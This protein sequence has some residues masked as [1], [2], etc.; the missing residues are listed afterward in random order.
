MRRALVCLCATLIGSLL[1]LVTSLAS[2]AGAV[3]SVT[4][5]YPW[6]GSPVPT[7]GSTVSGI[8]N[9]NLV[10]PGTDWT[11]GYSVQLSCQLEVPSG[12]AAQF[13]G[14]SPAIP[15]NGGQSY[16]PGGPGWEAGSGAY[17]G[18]IW[19]IQICGLDTNYQPVDGAS[20]DPMSDC[21]P[22]QTLFMSASTEPVVYQGSLGDYTACYANGIPG[23]PPQS[24]TLLGCSG[25]DYQCWNLYSQVHSLN[26][27]PAETASDGHSYESVAL[28]EDTVW[29]TDPSCDTCG[30]GS[31]TGP[32]N[33][34]MLGRPATAIAS[35]DDQQSTCSSS[36]YSSTDDEKWN[37]TDLSIN[38]ALAQA[39]YSYGSSLPGY[40]STNLEIGT[41]T[42][43]TLPTSWG[44][45]MPAEYL[46]GGSATIADAP[47][48][49]VAVNGP[50]YQPLPGGD[51]GVDAGTDSTYTFVV[52]GG[53]DYI[54]VDP[55]DEPGDVG[56]TG[57][58]SSEDGDID[59][60]GIWVGA[61]SGF[62][63][64]GSNG[65]A[66]VSFTWAYTTV[67]PDPWF[68]CVDGG[69]AVQWGDADDAPTGSPADGTIP[70]GGSADVDC[71]ATDGMEL[72]H[73]STWISGGLHDL[74]CL[75]IALVV[76]ENSAGQPA[77]PT[78]DLTSPFVSHV[79]FEWIYTAGTALHTIESGMTAG[80]A[81]GACDAPRIN[82]PGHTLLHTGGGS[83]GVQLPTPTSLDCSGAPAS[84]TES[85][86]GAGDLFGFRSLIRTILALGVWLAVLLICWRMMPWSK[87]G[88]G[89]EVLTAGGTIEGFDQNGVEVMQTNERSGSWRDALGSD[90]SPD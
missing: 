60:G 7:S 41:I 90:W 62:A 40:Y 61:D 82:L 29:N 9:E 79:P 76:P 19:C 77:F 78:S 68:Y 72:D 70:S 28:E 55:V 67:N 74:K 1:L 20:P 86:N 52:S 4:N 66:S 18:N 3:G 57:Y 44:A 12:E 87:S 36:A 75:L 64:V 65:E 38:E 80:I 34:E 13:M 24:A 8:C 17:S 63:H 69:S 32:G 30:Y 2:E 11:D 23:V 45:T 27:G 59:F 14:V 88:D 89:V 85:A 33:H 26:I 42:C 22:S 43:S 73:P 6:P 16:S 35:P 81:G 47:C 56:G 58:G 50:T 5:S 25:S 46:T 51:T 84:Y 39:E 21:I 83:F 10:E 48:T 49:L 15:A 31:G 37:G 71:Y 53:A 54:A